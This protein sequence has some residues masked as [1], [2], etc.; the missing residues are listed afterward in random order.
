MYKKEN[1]MYKHLTPIGYSSNARPNYGVLNN[2]GSSDDLYKSLI[3][4][5]KCRCLGTCRTDVGCT[6]KE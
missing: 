4:E 5:S 6:C 1:L 2:Y 3:S